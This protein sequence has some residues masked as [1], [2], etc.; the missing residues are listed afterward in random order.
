MNDYNIIMQYTKSRPKI[1]D[2]NPITHLSF[3][4]QQPLSL[5][6]SPNPQLRSNL[7][8][9]YMYTPD[10]NISPLPKS[11]SKNIFTQSGTYITRNSSLDGIKNDSPYY[12]KTKPRNKNAHEFNGTF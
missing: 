1:Q 9:S 11:Y 4:N 12:S 2:Y 5:E 8:S 10:K 6:N 3:Y 7:A